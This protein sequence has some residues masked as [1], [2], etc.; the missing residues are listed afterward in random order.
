MER[1][2][3]LKT[4]K[5]YARARKRVQN[6]K[7]FYQHLLSYCLFIPF[8][9]FINYRTYWDY[10]WF[11]YPLIGWG[12]GVAIHAFCIFIHKGTYSSNWEARK[13]EELMNKEQ[14]KW[15]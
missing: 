11:W 10:K 5:K 14:N 7:D 6:I 8:I 4:D 3:D 1:L 2:S 15:D 12:I 13:I 9:I